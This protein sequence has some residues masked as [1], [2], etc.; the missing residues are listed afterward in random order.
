MK[1]LGRPMTWICL[2]ASLSVAAALAESTRTQRFVV[3]VLP[4]VAVQSPA[5]TAILHGSDTDLDVHSRQTWNVAATSPG[6]VTVSFQVQDA[7]GNGAHSNPAAARLT[8]SVGASSGTARWTI[9]VPGS[10]APRSR[11]A[12]QVDAQVSSDTAGS[13]ELMLDVTVPK[14]SLGSPSQRGAQLTV[15][16]T[17]T[18]HD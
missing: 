15:T 11:N 6:G 18:S 8:L 13:A 5:A 14:E 7:A 3:H 16:A 4:R 9:A 17:V 12:Q 2:A 1:R 10:P